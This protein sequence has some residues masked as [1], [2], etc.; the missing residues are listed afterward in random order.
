VGGTRRSRSSLSALRVFLHH[1][2]SPLHR[3]S[4]ARYP[5]LTGTLGITLL[6]VCGLWSCNLVRRLPSERDTAGGMK[7]FAY[8]RPYLFRIVHVFWTACGCVDGLISMAAFSLRRCFNITPCCSSDTHSPLQDVYRETAGRCC[9]NS[10]LD[11][12][13]AWKLTSSTHPQV[14]LG[15]ILTY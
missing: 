4:T 3:L 13:G 2:D 9:R 12:S 14:G 1:V 6:S 15:P 10:I 5:N 8:L 7:I 11:R